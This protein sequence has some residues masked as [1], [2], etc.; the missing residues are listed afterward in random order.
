M[1]ANISSVVDLFSFSL[2]NISGA[3]V[4][5]AYRKYHNITLFHSVDEHQYTIRLLKLLK[6]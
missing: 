2:L 4:N 1:L 6:H 3:S 5:F